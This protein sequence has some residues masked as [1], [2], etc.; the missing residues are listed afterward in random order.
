MEATIKK[1][2]SKA[3]VWGAILKYGDKTLICDNFK[4]AR[5]RAEVLKLTITNK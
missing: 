5:E 1:T 2:K 3:G 4:D